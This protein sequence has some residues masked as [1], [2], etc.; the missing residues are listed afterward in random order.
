MTSLGLLISVCSRSHLV[1]ALA[2]NR[3][4]RTESEREGWGW[5]VDSAV[6]YSAKGVLEGIGSGL[7]GNEGEKCGL[8]HRPAGDVSEDI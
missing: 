1:R 3:G 8:L 7:P 6:T 2:E 5:G 4:P